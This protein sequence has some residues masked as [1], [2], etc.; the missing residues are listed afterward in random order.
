MI[1]SAR[2]GRR[3]TR[4]FRSLAAGSEQRRITTSAITDGFAAWSP[5]GTWTVFEAYRAASANA[6]PGYENYWVRPNGRRQTN[7][8]RLQPANDLRPDWQ[9]T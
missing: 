9:P 4:L 7:L 5:E 6:D 8:T 1:A 2:P 3:A